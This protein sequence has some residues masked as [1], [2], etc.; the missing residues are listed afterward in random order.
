MA[1]AVK[2]ILKSLGKMLGQLI[3]A[4][5]TKKDE[6]RNK[7]LYLVLGLVLLI[8]IIPIATLTAPGLIIKSFFDSVFDVNTPNSINFDINE[9]VEDTE[10]YKKCLNVYNEYKRAYNNRVGDI[11]TNLKLNNVLGYEIKLVE[12]EI[13]K[14]PIYPEVYVS[15]DYGDYDE[16]YLLAYINTEHHKEINKKNPYKF[17]KTEASS[18]IENI[19]SFSYSHSGTNP[20]YLSA[21]INV[22]GLEEI[23]QLY[24]FGQYTPEGISKED[25][26]NV[27]YKGL[28]GT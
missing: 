9:K 18:F 5:A 13:V 22:L 25:M 21:K 20:I 3:K 2:K 16:Y 28:K 1:A 11:A 7:A 8:V 15:V 17:S 27:S 6:E 10:I 19:S 4:A 12:G 26:F 24:F 14:I 23:S